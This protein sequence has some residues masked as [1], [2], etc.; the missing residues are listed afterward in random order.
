VDDGSGSTEESL[1][2]LEL[3]KKQ[4]VTVSVAT[5]HFYAV[6]HKLSEFL[7]RRERAARILAD[8]RSDGVPAVRL[9]AEVSYYEG[10][11]RSEEI[12]ALVIEG[13]PLL[14]LEM[15]EAPWHDRVVDEVLRM[16]D[17]HGVAV[18]LAHVERCLP[19]QK[20]HVIERLAEGEVLMQMNAD[21]FLERGT[22][23]F[24]V[25]MLRD[26][27]IHMIGSDCHNMTSRRPR[28]DEAYAEIR[29]RCGEDAAAWLGAVEDDFFAAE[30]VR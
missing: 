20:K 12:K 4:G 2:L 8:A 10:I 16:N 26:R 5:P 30:A 22:R 11:S 13:T 3:L 27:K 15:P 1:A 6:R 23:R 14:L 9:G 18:L 25:K 19:F 24:A 7:E 21:S 17:D 28:L 29:R